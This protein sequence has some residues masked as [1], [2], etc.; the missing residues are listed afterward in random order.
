MHYSHCCYGV[1]QSVPTDWRRE[2]GAGEP[3]GS[4]QRRRGCASQG[5]CG[6]SRAPRGVRGWPPGCASPPRAGQ[7][8]TAPKRVPRGAQAVMKNPRP[9][10]EAKRV[11]PAGA[12]LCLSAAAPGNGGT[13]EDRPEPIRTPPT[14]PGNGGGPGAGAGAYPMR[15]AAQ[16][17]HGRRP[18]RTPA[19]GGPRGRPGR[20]RH[21]LAAA[22]ALRTRLAHSGAAP[23]R[24][25]QSTRQRLLGS[26]AAL[27]H[28]RPRL[29]RG[30]HP[31]RGLGTLEYQPAP[32]SHAASTRSRPSDAAPSE[33]TAT[34]FPSTPSSLSRPL[35]YGGDTWQA[36]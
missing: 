9:A 17:S 21:V 31:G 15:A 27:D 25:Y 13:D 29:A 4:G 10:L 5:C 28:P 3:R 26:D 30:F 19:P 18:T 11:P 35:W 32:A 14:A 33:T 20:P 8:K 6:A 12:R 16:D 7:W 23:G 34:P 1:M 22:P 36:A 2:S 24:P